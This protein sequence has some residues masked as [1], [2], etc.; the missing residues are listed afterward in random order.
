MK[1]KHVVKVTR[2]EFELDDGAVFPIEPPLDW[3]PTPEEFQEHYDRSRLL[4]ESIENARSDDSNPRG[5]GQHGEDRSG[6]DSGESS[7]NTDE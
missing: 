2:T 5:V 3:D 6:E 7:S 1:R 4:V